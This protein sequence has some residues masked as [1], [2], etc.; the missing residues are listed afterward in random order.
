MVIWTN[1]VLRQDHP[2]FAGAGDNVVWQRERAG[3]AD[4]HPT[5][6]M[7]DRHALFDV[8]GS[9]IFSKQSA[10]DRGAFDVH[11]P[12]GKRANQCAGVAVQRGKADDDL[13]FDAVAVAKANE[14][15]PVARLPARVRR[16]ARPTDNFEWLS[17]PLPFAVLIFAPPQ[18][19]LRQPEFAVFVFQVVL[20]FRFRFSFGFG[21]RSRW[22]PRSPPSPRRVQPRANARSCR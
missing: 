1:G 13:M 11:A 2:L 21:F 16:I 20:G 10:R 19:R 15:A 3:A 8:D 7:H 9:E 18:A 14:L 17:D 5:I 6:A 22:Q 12:M 4:V